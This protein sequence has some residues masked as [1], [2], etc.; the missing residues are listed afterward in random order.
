MKG[1]YM[2]DGVNEFNEHKDD[3]YKSYDANNL[4]T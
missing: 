4:G 2:V 1:I 3:E